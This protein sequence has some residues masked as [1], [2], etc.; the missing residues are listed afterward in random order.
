M[1]K[2]SESLLVQIGAK[3]FVQLEDPEISQE[4]LKESVQIEGG[5]NIFGSGD[6]LLLAKSPID[7]SKDFSLNLE[8]WNAL[9]PDSQSIKLATSIPALGTKSGVFWKAP[10]AQ[11]RTDET[12][13]VGYI[14]P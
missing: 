11:F 3:E 8:G 12:I 1:L 13:G 2:L 9:F 10:L 14:A 5:R 6:K 7:I 4:R